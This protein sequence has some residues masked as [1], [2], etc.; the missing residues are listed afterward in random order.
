MKRIHLL[1]AFIV[2]VSAASAQKIDKET[3]LVGSSSNMG[4]NNSTSTVF[5]LDLKA[6]YF[7]MDNLAVGGR[8][9]YN[10]GTSN[11]SIGIFGRY[12]YEGK[13]FGGLG[14]TQ[15]FPSSG[16]SYTQ[17]PLEV[18][19]AAFVTKNIAI[20]PSLNV[21]LSKAQNIVGLNLGFGLY[22]HRK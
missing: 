17:V 9:D 12:Y 1:I 15:V 11:A 22:L 16:S 14:F 5:N 19:Y 13:I 18:G 8:L 7:V 6:G 4:I 10:S 20:E 3:V 2:I 21:T